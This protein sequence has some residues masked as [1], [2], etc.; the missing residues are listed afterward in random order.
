MRHERPTHP[1]TRAQLGIWLGQRLDP[2]NPTYW[3]AEALFLYGALDR[4]VFIAALD[5]ALTPLDTLHVRYEFSGDTPHAVPIEPDNAAQLTE[6]EFVGADDPEAAASAWIEAELAQPVDLTH[7]PLYRNF[8]ARLDD[9]RHLWAFAAHHIALDGYA[10]GLVLDA[11]AAHYDALLRHTAPP[12]PPT[13][14]TG[15]RD[16][17]LVYQREHAAAD[18]AWWREHLS[19]TPAPRS[20]APVQPIAHSVRRVRRRLDA[21]A[22]TAVRQAAHDADVDWG[23]WLL[24]LAA[25]WLARETGA[26]TQTLGLPVMLRPG[27]CALRVPCM[28]MNIVPLV[29]QVDAR[30]SVSQLAQSVTAGLRAIRPHMRYRYED[31]R[32]DLAE[33]TPGRRPFGT[34]VNLMPF[35]RPNR[36]GPLAARQLALAAGPVEDLALGLALDGDSLRVDFEANPGAYDDAR[37]ATLADTWFALLN[38]A[39]ARPRAPL[40]AWVDFDAPCALLYGEALAAPAEPVLDRLIATAACRLAHPAIV[41]GDATLDYVTLMTEVR[42][43]AGRLAAAGVASGDWIALLLPREP[44]TLIALLAVH[45]LGAAWVPLDPASPDAH[46]ARVLADAQPAR[47]L[48]TSNLAARLPADV[49]TLDLD[50][51]LPTAPPAGSPRTLSASTPAYVIYTSGSTGR[52]NGVKIGRD[53]LAHFVAA[54]GRRY[55]ITENDRILQFAPLHFDA[56]IEEIF[57]AFAHGA[58]LVL[59]DD[60]MLE[61]PRNFADALTRHRISVLDLPTAYWHELAWA[62]DRGFTPPDCLRLVIIGGEAALGERIERWR[63]HAPTHIRLENT[64]GPTEATVVCA[65]AT[66]AG[67]E[68]IKWSAG[69]PP[70][71]RP[72]PGETLVVIDADRVP[73]RRGEPGQLAITGPTLAHGYHDRAIVEAERFV[74]L[75]ALPD[76]P[77]AYLTGDRV[78]AGD[79]GQLVYLGRLDDEFKFSGHRIDPAEVETALLNCAGVREAAVLGVETAA[80][81]KRLVAFVVVDTTSPTPDDA[82][83]G[84]ELGGL[85]PAAAVPTR[86][87]RVAALPRNANNKIDRHGLR[88][89]DTANETPASAAT[90]PT[91]AAVRAVWAEVLG[92]APTTNSD[93]FGLGGKSL[94]AIQ[95]ANRLGERLG[96][97][98][99]V[100]WI[101]RYSHAAALAL[102]LDAKPLHASE[103]VDPLAPLLVIQR[104]DADT[105]A[106]FCVHPAEGLAWAYFG[107]AHHLPDL[108]ILGLQ[109]PQLTGEPIADWDT[110][111]ANYLA[112]VRA[113]QPRGP[114]RLLGWSS[115]GG[116]AHALASALE[117]LGETVELLA[118]MDSFPA[119]IWNGKPLPTRRDALQNLLD[120]IGSTE[121]A[122]DGRMLSNDEIAG[123]LVAQGSA[124]ADY[125]ID[126]LIDACLV[127]MLI[128]RHARHP[129]FRGPALYFRAADRAAD[130]PEWTVW[131]PFLAGPL[132]RLDIA[133]DH[134][135]MSLPEPLAAIGATLR[136]RLVHAASYSTGNT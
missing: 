82:A 110:L 111:V 24:T 72:L 135:R 94:Q 124:L 107:L 81:L 132:E 114:Y 128:Y 52:P 90:S 11:V 77:R 70:I 122:R 10:F 93:F 116:I 83:L 12:P 58:T 28:A 97:D 74:T 108:P 17:D 39:W 51:A 37:L 129:V 5:A 64:Y 22:F 36:F 7:G 44:R 23:T 88:A 60:A 27:T 75:D 38:N 1:L 21:A 105:P 66:L 85:L 40:G 121:F 59:R 47:V 33:H 50:V 6:R 67:P 41:C 8:V 2:A 117:T 31:L 102:A 125:D 55:A 80:G 79:D 112:R 3:T 113:V 29:V 34:V 118:M 69:P 18:R 98:V 76:A 19:G 89:L 42:T 35:T 91:E 9:I 63:R 13:G 109:F 131:E 120:V 134:R 126:K 32:R 53:A 95:A 61:S 45:W 127:S 14:L 130:L 65:T 57:L 115:G 15:V 136:T 100:S 20:I 68:R 101:F 30:L 92:V 56:C 119:D 46:I 133:S 104:G 62:L 54:A 123:L 103:V 43:L 99:P 26:R 106:L 78:V 48:T 96:R 86:F 16:E 71:G 49:P 25:I 73:L 87:V 4:S 84:A